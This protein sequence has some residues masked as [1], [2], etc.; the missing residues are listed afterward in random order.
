MDEHP[1]PEF[2]KELRETLNE[3]IA[4][5]I[6]VRDL[7]AT[8]IE[9]S[10]M[11]QKRSPFLRLAWGL[12]LAILLALVVVASPR[13][14]TLLKQW[15]GY[16]P[17]VGFVQ[18]SETLRVLSAPVTIKKDGLQVSIE[19]GAVDAQHTILLQHIA[20]YT[21]PD[22]LGE[23]Y[24]QTP[25][26][27]VL[28]DG[29][30]VQEISYQ[31]TWGNTTNLSSD[32]YLG[33]YEFNALPAGQMDAILEIPCVMSDS[34]FTDFKFDLH[35]K[36]ADAG[37]VLSVIELPTQLSA[38]VETLQTPPVAV[39]SPQVNSVPTAATA[40]EG[41]AIV[42]ESETALADGYILTGSYQ[43]TDP[44]F[45]GFS[46]YPSVVQ[47]KDANG[48]DVNIELVDPIA[49][50][51]NPAAKKLP[52]AFHIFG[53][54]QA[55]P[56]TISADA[57]I[58]T[59]RDSATFQFDFGTN[60][61]VG[62]TWNTDLDVPIAG[63]IIHVQTIELTAGRTSTELGFTFAMT[64]DV[65]VTGA[66][67][68]DA[69]PIIKGNGGGGGGG[70]GGMDDG[71]T[72]GPFTSGWALEGYSPAGVKTFKVSDLSLMFHGN[73]QITWSPSTP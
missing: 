28:P 22:R 60:P 47:V 7:R 19:R 57:L 26:R 49:T 5:P 8:L 62:Q 48:Q 17:G 38:P 25:A 50:N 71:Y 3:T 10:T 34:K 45:D 44:R 1:S 4:N 41:F 42:L 51:T 20:G 69:N 55:L 13:A 54:E 56:L 35:F 65:N 24:C 33:R 40:V 6:F 31:T 36:L 67:I 18:P 37:Q 21:N 9:R 2:E 43:W 68:V 70:G 12:A 72:V 53:R 16:V 52:F 29:T 23:R 30:V 58:G 64:S 32:Q 15:L 66:I 11:K 46:L 73:W 63:H 59:L 27:L 39:S 14:A 61:Q